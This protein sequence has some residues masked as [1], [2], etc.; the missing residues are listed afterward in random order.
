MRAA[1]E[2]YFSDQDLVGQWLEDC[3]DIRL[4]NQDIW[5]RSSDLFDSWTAYAHR[6]GEQPGS[7]KSFG[8][9]MQKRGFKADRRE[10][11]RVFRRIR[12]RAADPLD[13]NTA[14][15]QACDA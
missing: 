6:A 1:T 8:M 4:G 3:C 13:F 9:T 14:K 5:D 15:K 11:V 7:K 12:L 10:G 2:A